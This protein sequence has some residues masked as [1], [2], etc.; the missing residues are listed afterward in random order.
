M[1]ALG[2]AL[3][4]SGTTIVYQKQGSCDGVNAILK[5]TTIS[6]SAAYYPAVSDAGAPVP[7]SCD[8]PVADA[9]TGGQVVDLGVSDV[10]AES[11]PGITMRDAN[12]V[13]DFW[14]PNQVMVFVAPLAATQ[15][16]NISAEAAYLVM[17]LTDKKVSPWTDANK[18]YIRNARSGT[19]TMLA[20]A[21][22]LDAASWHGTDSTSAAGVESNVKTANT[23]DPN[24]QAVLGIVSTGEADRDR[25][26][27]KVLGFQPLGQTCAYWPDSSLTTFDKKWVRSGEYQIW[28]PLHM[29]AK[30]GSAGGAPTNATV[31]KIVGYFDGSVMPPAGKNQIIDL[32]IATHTVPQCA[33]KVKR[34]T[35]LGAYT[36]YTDPHPCGCYFELKANGTAPASCKTCM[37]DPDCGASNLICSYGYCEAK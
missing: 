28:G 8:L 13:G 35:E 31:A 30:V 3:Y 15:V 32:E 12:T 21:I 7:A 22:H 18:L 1:E 34:S 17:G 24:P 14:G 27:M 20:A 25:A 36:P 33:M 9:G 37:T 10:F 11:C 26:F 4:P 23:S 16:I 19:Q 29:L 6:G 2:A 5:N